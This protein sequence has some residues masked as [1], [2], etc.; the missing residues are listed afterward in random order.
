[1][2]EDRLAERLATARRLA[3]EARV[4]R[5]DELLT[6]L[7]ADAATEGGIPAD[8]DVEVAVLRATAWTNTERPS[9]AWDAL[10]HAQGRLAEAS[11][12][13]RARFHAAGGTVAYLFGDDDTAIDETVLALAVMAGEPPTPQRALALATGGLTLSYTRLFPL[14]AEV[15]D[16]ALD[17]AA[18]A[19]VPTARIHAQAQYV[20]L[21]WGLSLDHLGLAEDC[22]ARWVD[23]R[24]HHEAAVADR[25]SLPDTML[26]FS[27]AEHALLAARNGDAATARGQLELARAARDEPRS[28][29]LRR[30]LGHAEGAAL[31]AEGRLAEARRVLQ[32]VWESV[33]DRRVPAR[34][35][36][37]P[38]LLARVAEADG[39]QEE[40][41][42][43]YREVYTRYGRT[44]QEAWLARETA[45]RLRV[46][47]E[48]LVRRSREL[49]AD[50]LTDPLTGVPNRRAFDAELPR[51][52]TAA[53]AV[54]APLSLAV[55]DVDRFKRINDRYGHPTG[56]EVL[57][58]VARTLR[59]R[60]RDSDT[61]ARYG[62]D[63]FVLCL[64]TRAAEA[65]AVVARLAA[66]VGAHPWSA[67]APGL[68][69][70]VSTGV[71][72]LG[73]ADT[74]PTLFFAADQALLAA[75]RRRPPDPA[76][77]PVAATVPEE[78]RATL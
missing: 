31:W 14:A 54:G 36:D 43:W 68:G 4:D 5:L 78:G 72:E 3:S 10:Q 15:M 27:H 11:P 58:R 23:V 40:A 47:Q 74:A 41:L 18:A 62:G 49:E 8:L 73:P 25:A 19:G 55:L 70:S 59:E 1:M 64:P 51:L 16:E 66:A 69:V 75:K 26:A 33:R 45:A 32:V 28:P 24:R 34:T 22:A 46:E 77:D 39:R 67:L 2:P 30:L 9:E 17:T 57:R 50:A 52:V 38:L 61:V 63:E 20:H 44:Q 12:A 13:A 48:A 71:G 60:C 7:R 35:E 42:R 53:Q 65:E 56:D 29:S 37:V 6:G 21:T 76:T